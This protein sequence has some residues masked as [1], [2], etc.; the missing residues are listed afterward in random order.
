M[1][2]KDRK[3]IKQTE[4]RISKEDLKSI[5]RASRDLQVNAMR[6]GRRIRAVTFVDRKKETNRN[7]CRGRV[8]Y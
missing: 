3:P 7:V 5:R 4:R 2:K 1:R 8:R 6:E